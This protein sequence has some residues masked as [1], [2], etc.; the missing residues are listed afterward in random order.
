MRTTATLTVEFVL[1]SDITGCTEEAIRLAGVLGCNV[2]F[3]FNDTTVAVDAQSSA[4]VVAE[5]YMAPRKPGIM[6]HYIVGW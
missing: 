5:R 4:A 3:K 6:G 1:G 2:E